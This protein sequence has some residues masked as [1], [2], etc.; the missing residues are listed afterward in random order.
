[1]GKDILPLFFGDV[2]QIITFYEL[3][4]ILR[5]HHHLPLRHI[6]KN[7]VI[8]IRNKGENTKFQVGHMSNPRFNHNRAFK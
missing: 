2:E 7:M 4:N 3:N 1:M 5:Q 6:A 8:Y